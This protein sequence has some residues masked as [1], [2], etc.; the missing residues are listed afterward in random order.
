MSMHSVFCPCGK[1]ARASEGRGRPGK[2]CCDRC[3]NRYR[4]QKYRYNEKKAV[5]EKRH[6][7]TLLLPTGV[8]RPLTVEQSL[9]FTRLLSLKTV[10]HLSSLD[11]LRVT[12]KLYDKVARL[13]VSFLPLPQ[14]LLHLAHDPLYHKACTEGVVYYHVE[15][16][17]Y[18]QDGYL[19]YC[20]CLLDRADVLDMVDEVIHPSVR[21]V[22]ILTPLVWNVGFVVGFLSALSHAQYVEADEG[23]TV[24]ASLVTPLV[25]SRPGKL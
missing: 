13:N 22:A 17:T 2:F 23:M 16:Y 5:T 20:P 14:P 18:D 7:K 8:E 24:L 11:Y 10:H 4:R 6:G 15:Q 9:A 25:L 21:E 19:D 3:A 1:P 12:T